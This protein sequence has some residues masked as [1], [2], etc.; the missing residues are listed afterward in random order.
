MEKRITLDQFLSIC[1]IDTNR[2]HVKVIYS[3]DKICKSIRFINVWKNMKDL[4]SLADKYVDEISTIVDIE[5]K[6]PV[7]IIYLTSDKIKEE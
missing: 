7:I 2:N 5:D 3:D 1:T 6:E 4:V